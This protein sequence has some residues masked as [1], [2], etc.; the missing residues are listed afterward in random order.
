M[1]EAGV[2]MMEPKTP[3]LNPKHQANCP[4]SEIQARSG[5]GARRHSQPRGGKTGCSASRIGYRQ[6]CRQAQQQLQKQNTTA[7]VKS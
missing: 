4:P 5:T 3:F 7:L 6:S 2:S 1:L